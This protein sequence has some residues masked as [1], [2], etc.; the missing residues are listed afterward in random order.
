MP[1]DGAAPLI[2]SSG[3]SS[4]D[5][6]CANAM[7]HRWAPVITS[8]SIHYTKLYERAEKGKKYV[9]KPRFGCGAEA[10][11]LVMKFEKTEAFIAND[12]IASEYIDG[13]HLSVSLIAGKKP[14][15]LTVNR[16]FIEFRNNFV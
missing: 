11:S 6:S 9:I 8:Y 16:Q 10:T 13:K 12:C 4:F 15:P 5:Q 14:L 1:V 2:M 3:R 7:A